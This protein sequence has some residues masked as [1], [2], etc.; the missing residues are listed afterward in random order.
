MKFFLSRGYPKILPGHLHLPLASKPSLEFYSELLANVDMASYTCGSVSSKRVLFAQL[1]MVYCKRRIGGGICV[2]RLVACVLRAWA[3][4][5]RT[6]FEDL[7]CQ[8]G[9]EI[10]VAD[11]FKL[12]PEQL[13]S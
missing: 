9:D 10:I 4:T 13:V 12:H 1:S 5:R 11:L 7:E 2:W 8:S 6:D 3:D